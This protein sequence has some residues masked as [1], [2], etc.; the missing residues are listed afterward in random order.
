MSHICRQHGA[1]SNNAGCWG[2]VVQE[3]VGRLLPRPFPACITNH[4]QVEGVPNA[5]DMLFIISVTRV[6]QRLGIFNAELSGPLL[7]DVIHST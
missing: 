7:K 4:S 5:F 6:N 2:S 1:H 3:V